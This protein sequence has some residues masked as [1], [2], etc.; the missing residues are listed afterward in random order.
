V[1]VV[2]NLY[3]QHPSRSFSL[4]KGLPMIPAVAPRVGPPASD[5]QD[6]AVPA[7]LKEKCM[8]QFVPSVVPK[9][10]SLSALAAIALCIAEIAFI[11]EK[12]NKK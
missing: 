3:S 7:G 6:P 8:M 11:N 9:P 12:D 5:S 4:K 10:R 1:S 2:L